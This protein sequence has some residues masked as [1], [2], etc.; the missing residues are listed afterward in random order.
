MLEVESIGIPKS[1]RDGRYEGRGTWGLNVKSMNHDVVLQAHLYIF[2]NF[3]EVQPYLS[4]HKRLTKEKYPW[5]SDM[6][7]LKENNR[8]FI[9]WFNE[10]I[11]NDGSASETIKWMSYMLKFNVV[12]WIANYISKFS[13][14]TKSKDDCSTM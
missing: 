6:W 8:N 12:T 11:Y 9:S 5:M 3:D 14:Y 4:A 13:F 7:L 1:R 10:I 2:N